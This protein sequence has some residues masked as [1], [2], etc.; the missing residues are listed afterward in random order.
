MRGVLQQ[1]VN[2]YISM[3][4]VG[5]LALGAAYFIIHVANDEGFAVASSIDFLEEGQ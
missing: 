4:F 1:Q 3:I 2:T 5:A